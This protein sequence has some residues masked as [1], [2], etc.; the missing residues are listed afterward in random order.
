M[1]K[2]WKELKRNL[3]YGVTKW[4][5]LK[6]QNRRFKKIKFKEQTQIPKIYYNATYI[7]KQQLNIITTLHIKKTSYKKKICQMKSSLCHKK[8]KEKVSSTKKMF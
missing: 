3:D 1:Y 8:A 7:L 6:S 4:Y 5:L 2:T